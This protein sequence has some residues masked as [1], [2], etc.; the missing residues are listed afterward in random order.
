MLML[1]R[2][3]IIAAVKSFMA[4]LERGLDKL[5]PGELNRKTG[6]SNSWIT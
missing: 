3:T 6:C 2:K 5:L 1:M 4:E